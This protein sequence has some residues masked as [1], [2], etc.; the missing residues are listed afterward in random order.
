MSAP[1]KTIFIELRASA[2][3][4]KSDMADAGTALDRI[5][6][7]GAEAGRKVSAGVAVAS[8]SLGKLVRASV[9]AGVAVEGIIIAAAKYS[10][11][12]AASA[13]NTEGLVNSYR[14]LRIA[15]DPSDVHP[16]DHRD[17]HF[18]P[19]QT[20][21]ADVNARAKLIEQQALIAA[22]SGLSF[23][24]GRPAR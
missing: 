1:V 15:L 2:D 5:G 12:A 16:R 4:L 9:E 18:W 14:A 19:E 22:K 21:R 11:V 23:G 10:G 3:R 24:A 7:G 8:E 6:T 13:G 17:G 20:N